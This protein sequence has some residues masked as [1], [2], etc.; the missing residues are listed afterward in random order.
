MPFCPK[1]R[2]EFQ[3]WVKGC[4]DC[5]ENLVE[6]LEPVPK[7]VVSNENPEQLVTIGSFLNPIEAHIISKKLES[8]GI[9]SF[10]ADE[11]I[12]TANWFYSTAIG[13]VRV[14][15]RESDAEVALKI[16]H[17]Q[18]EPQELPPVGEG[19]PKCGSADIH[20][21]PFHLRPMFIFWLVEVIFGGDVGLLLPLVKRKWKCN[22]CGHQWK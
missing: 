13:G 3:D 16:L 18:N 19:C 22:A 8:E 10:V 6:K 1:C 9:W 21:E 11:H 12:V 5:G 14:K 2:D 15:V 20:Y 17:A 4:P 7:P